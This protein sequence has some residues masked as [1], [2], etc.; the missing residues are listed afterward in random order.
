MQPIHGTVYFPHHSH[1]A[2]DASSPS[3]DFPLFYSAFDLLMH[4]Q[5]P[6]YILDTANGGTASAL[7]LEH[8]CPAACR[9]R[10]SVY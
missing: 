10:V 8:T 2:Q 6:D 7:P 9:D 1:I 3:A 4:S 5:I